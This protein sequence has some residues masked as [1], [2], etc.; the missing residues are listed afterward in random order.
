LPHPLPPHCLWLPPVDLLAVFRVPTNNTHAEGVETILVDRLLSV[1][2]ISRAGGPR[3]R[4]PPETSAI[5]CLVHLFFRQSI[6][7]ASLALANSPILLS[8]LAASGARNLRLFT[9][10]LFC[11]APRHFS[12]RSR[13]RAAPLTPWSRGTLLARRAMDG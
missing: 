3:R 4:P 8:R 6:Y 13:P 2:R 7:I 9:V 10:A 5:S 1:S 11:I 12:S